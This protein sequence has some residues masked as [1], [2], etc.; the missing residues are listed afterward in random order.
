MRT[1]EE[2]HSLLQKP[3]KG[4]KNQR[5]QIGMGL[6]NLNEEALYNVLRG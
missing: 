6:G 2:M 5:T 1:Y 4:K 3:K